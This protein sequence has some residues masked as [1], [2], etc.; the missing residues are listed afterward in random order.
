MAHTPLTQRLGSE[1]EGAQFPCRSW[2]CTNPWPFGRVLAG[3]PELIVEAWWP[4][5]EVGFGIG[6]TWV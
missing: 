2:G 5:E 1:A 4:G 3:L 6:Q